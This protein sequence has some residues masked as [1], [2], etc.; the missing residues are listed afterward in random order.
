MSLS[1]VNVSRAESLVVLA[2][3]V[4]GNLVAAGISLVSITAVLYGMGPF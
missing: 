2:A 1:R 4:L 3:L